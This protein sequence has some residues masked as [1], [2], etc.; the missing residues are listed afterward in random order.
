MNNLFI[1]IEQHCNGY[2]FELLNFLSLVSILT[3]IFVII[4]KNPII[5]ILF[6][7][8][9]FLSIASYLML[10]GM[11]FIGLSYLLVYIG[12]VSI[13]F[14]FILMLINIR[15]SE[16]QSE[17]SNSLPL[18]LIMGLC[19]YYIVY[20]VI[21]V[22]MYKN[23]IINN[24]INTTNEKLFFVTS[25]IWDGM[26]IENSHIVSIGNIMYTSYFLW[27]IITSIILLLAMVGTIIIT[28]R[29]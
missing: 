26:L 7:I 18:A 21:P 20:D 16:L 19:F 13:L 11:N 14:L 12:A 23:K 27:I 2:I 25:S 6:L 24:M 8:C 22:D 17:T 5:S 10:L 29:S 28:I 4:T 9:L 1:I 15:I 3:G